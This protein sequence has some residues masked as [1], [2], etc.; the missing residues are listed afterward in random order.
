MGVRNSLLAAAVCLCLVDR[1]EIGITTETVVMATIIATEVGLSQGL[2]HFN[3]MK[4]IANGPSHA[5]F[6]GVLHTFYDGQRHIARNI[7]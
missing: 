5:V 6:F 3:I 4:R 7:T 2:R 1:N